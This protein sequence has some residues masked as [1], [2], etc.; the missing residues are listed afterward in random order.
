MQPFDAVVIGLGIMGS[1]AC[2]ELA[3]RGRRVL[4]ID[5]HRLGHALG[6]SHGSSRIIRKCY[7]EHSD[8]VPLLESAYERWDELVRLSG[9]PPEHLFR[10]TGGLY[11]GP[12]GC[13]AIEGARRSAETHGL[14]HELL[15]RAEIA[16]RFP[17][18]RV[19]DAFVGFYEPDAGY[20]V[21]EAALE[22]FQRLAREAGATLWDGVDGGV[23]GWSD[24]GTGEP[25]ELDGLFKA[26]PRAH[27]II[28]TTGAWVSRLLDDAGVRVSATRQ[29]L[30]WVQP[31]RPE[32]FLSGTCP[33]WAI[34]AA[35]LGEG[36]YYG[37]PVLEGP[38]QRLGMKLARHAPG[39]EVD[40]DRV[41]RTQLPSDEQTFRP[42]LSRWMPDADG[43]LLSSAVCLY[44]N[45]PDQHF[46]IDRHPRWPN[47]VMACG[48]SGHGFKFASVMGEI[49]ADLVTEGA[50][51]HPIGFLSLDRFRGSTDRPNAGIAAS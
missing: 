9:L 49:L 46:I 23:I 28:V 48:F 12:R 7:Y 51:R 2:C 11:L 33:V 18:F 25:F 6:S 5:C 39:P 42:C 20:L 43:P 17:Q 27:H 34:D 16:R 24:R 31:L 32:Q 22:A 8:Y 15:T 10:R 47:V 38:H 19:D 29:V 3:R 21:P 4:G 1:A 26:A 37:F 41:A 50:T 36:L 30:G 35:H 13:E 14:A 44:E 45:S 40:A